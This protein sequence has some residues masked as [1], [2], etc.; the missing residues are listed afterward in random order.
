MPQDE[1]RMDEMLRALK[2]T[3]AALR[4]A[5]VPFAVAGGL[6]CWARGAPVRDD[7]VDIVVTDDDLPRAM[8]ALEEAGMETE[9]PP[10]EWLM[11]AHDGGVT[12]DLMVHP[13]GLE[14]T[15]EVL[16]R[17]EELEVHAVTMPVLPIDDVLVTQLL[18][19]S[20]HHM[21]YEGLIET[22]RAVREQVDWESVRRRT[23]H[24]P[25]ARGFFTIIEGLGVVSPPAA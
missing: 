16:A 19:M 8:A 4:D 23:E 6:A 18:S 17:A 12:V 9:D 21:T 15:L 2:R 13:S 25:F 10:E 20:E 1:E 24:D 7:D 5:G 22:A 14:I 11:K 3:A